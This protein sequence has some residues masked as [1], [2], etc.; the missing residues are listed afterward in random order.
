MMNSPSKTTCP[1][2]RVLTMHT[3]TE[4]LLYTVHDATGVATLT[5]NRPTASN[6][7]SDEMLAGMLELLPKIQGDARVK[8][9][10]L[11][12]SGKN[13]CAG[14]DL[15]AMRDR[16]GMFE[17]NPVELRAKYSRGLQ[18]ITR[19]FDR[20]EKPVVCAINGAAI[21]AGLDLSLMCDVRIA[22][23]RARFGST[24]A[25][26]GLIP[27][28]GGAFLLTRAVG[29]SRATELILS[30]R[31]IKSEEALRIGLV[32]EVVPHDEVLSHATTRA[33]KIARLPAPAVQMAKVALYRTYTQQIEPALQLTSALQGLVQHTPEHEAAVLAMLERLGK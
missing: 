1:Y 19:H 18:E 9:L 28:D 7:W 6:A 32:H 20:L 11:T 31:V 25:G 15:E 27:G 23:E 10:L 5:L 33:E 17:G 16:T 4:Q 13:F 26:V 21:G 3:S 24:F 22:S 12:G 30:A 29:F 2:L 14:G 8:V